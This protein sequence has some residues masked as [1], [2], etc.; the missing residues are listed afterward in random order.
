MK[1]KEYLAKSSV[2]YE[3][4]EHKPTFTA[5]HMAAEEH[6]PGL[7]VAKPVLVK[8]DEKFYLCVLPGCYKIDLDE[9]RGQLGVSNLSLADESEMAKVFPDCDLGAEPPFGELYGIETIMDKSLEEDE[10][11]IFQGG[12]HE[13]AIKMTIDEYLTLA[14]PVVLN[15]SYP[16]R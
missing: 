10:Y 9:L 1:V 13:K 11:V 12:S 15:F 16:M 5:Q 8:A 6:V 2:H 14:K 3:E 7:Y 4:L